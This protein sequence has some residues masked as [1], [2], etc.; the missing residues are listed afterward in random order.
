MLTG[1]SMDGKEEIESIFAEKKAKGEEEKIELECHFCDKK[2]A[3][4]REDVE[5]LF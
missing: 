3:F 1:H 4:Y 5:K 2:Y